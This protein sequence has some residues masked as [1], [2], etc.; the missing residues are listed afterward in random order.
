MNS[1][2]LIGRLTRAPVTRFEGDG[3]QVCT[4]TLAVTESSRE[5]KAY[6]VY[7]PCTSWGRSAETCALLNAADVVAIVGKL[8]WRAHKAKC[9]EEHSQLVVSVREMAVLE[10]AMEIPA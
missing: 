6:T 3:L 8:I 10:T 9:G 1:V 2:Q 7:V 4:F 5:G